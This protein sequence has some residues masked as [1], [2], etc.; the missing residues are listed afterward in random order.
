MEPETA[1]LPGASEAAPSRSQLSRSQEPDGPRTEA[2]LPAQAGELPLV[3]QAFL[4]DLIRSQLLGSSAVGRFLGQNTTGFSEYANIDH[5]C[6]DLVRADLL[7]DYQTRRILAGNTHG[8]ILGN[9][10]VMER[11]GGGSMGTVYMAEHLYM[12]RRSAIKVVPVDEACP[13]VVVERFYSEMRVLA[14][15]HHP[16]IVTAFDAGRLA[17]P[18]PDQPVLLY[19]VMELVEGGDLDRYVK[20]HGPVEVGQA[21]EWI[22]QAANGL[23]EAHDHYLVHRDLKPSNLLLTR[24]G[25]VKIVDFGLVRQFCSLLTGPRGLLGTIAFMAP[26]QSQDPTTVG[27]QADIYGLGATL[28][29]LLTGRAPYPQSKTISEA[30]R[31]LRDKQPRRLNALRPDLPKELDLLLDRLLD[32]DPTRRPALPLTVMKALEPF[33][34]KGVPNYSGQGSGVR[35]DMASVS[36]LS[37][38]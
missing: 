3:A 30:V 32:H 10:R 34:R 38:D 1:E 21:C 11:L 20:A 4:E 19:L 7:T 16:N 25:Q 14:E 33:C 36:L 29:W 37:P 13:A 22:R 12:K 26:E 24:K 28:F 18:T 17:P 5:L 6:A 23:Q 35:E 9:Y 8:L 31:M 27:S 15:L 2:P